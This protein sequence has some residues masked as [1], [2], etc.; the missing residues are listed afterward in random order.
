MKNLITLTST[1]L[2]AAAAC[3]DNK[4]GTIP[5]ADSG[6]L[7]G[8]TDPDGS[9]EPDA[10]SDSMSMFTPPTPMA[11]VRSAM[12]PDQL[13][14]AVAGPGG[15]FYVAGWASTAPTGAPRHIFVGKLGADG[16]PDA[17]FGTEGFL[18]TTINYRGAV[19]ELDLVA[20]ADGSLLL[21][22]TV[23]AA[24]VNPVDQ[25]DTDIALIKITA[26][27]ALDTTFGGGDGIVTHNLNTSILNSATPPTPVGRD[28]VR[29][30]ALG[31][32]GE[33]FI[34]GF[35][36]GE[37]NQTGTLNPRVDTD[38]VVAKFTAA[39]ALDTTWGGGDGKY[40]QDIYL[41][42]AHSNATPHAIAVDSGAV[43]AGG[44]ANAGLSTG[45]QAVLFRLQADGTLDTGFASGGV[46][47]DVVL[48]TQTEIYGW[49]RHDNAL[50]TSGYGRQT[51]AINDYIA[52][53][54]DLTTGARD[55]TT[56]GNTM[57]KTG[58]AFFDA[59]P[60]DATGGNNARNA[61]GLPDGKTL[62][63]GSSQRTA[64]A[65]MMT[66]QVTDAV[67]AVLDAD[68][69]LDTA[70]GTG[71]MTFALGDDGVDQFWGGAVS[72]TNALVVGWRGARASTQ[73]AADNDDSYVVVL[74][75]Q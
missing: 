46:F 65:D 75:L 28:G 36:R 11:L 60:A 7:D 44:Y 70:Y 41:M 48:G 54:F 47:H 50:V 49:A 59:T 18:T 10:P 17:T 25:N 69:D 33:I 3:G 74:P 62:M 34:I 22:A 51:G 64:N 63:I 61:V 42:N 55:T 21:T 2:L 1:L 24:A 35:Q 43:V 13:L 15:S 72:G 19:S 12:G 66:P 5:P 52:L 56:W 67:I 40:L 71:I 30:V 14:A 16:T 31:A 23:D 58:L 6:P 45:P 20:L 32:A 27:G 26:N 29:N 73:T 37:G 9:D 57:P 68:G 53:R 39:G 8:S 38:F 4:T